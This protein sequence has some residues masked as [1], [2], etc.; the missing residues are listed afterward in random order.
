MAKIILGGTEIME[1]RREIKKGVQDKLWNRNFILLLQGQLISI[2]GD[3]I[4]EM[5]L[6]IWILAKTR[7][8]TL[9]GIIMATSILPKIFIS[10]FAGTFI[11]RHSRKKILIVSDVVSGITVCIIGIATIIGCVEIWMVILA[12]IIVG[13]CGCF[14]NPTINSAIPDVVPKNSL[15]KANSALSSIGTMNNMAGYAFGGFLVQIIGAPILFL[16]N[17]VSF[18]LSA[19]AEGF[20]KIPRIEPSIKKVTFREDMKAGFNY[21]KSN[22]GL[23]YLYITI[24]FLNFFASMSMTLTLPLFKMH[25]QLGVGL[26]GIA[27]AINTFGMLVG[28]SILAIKGLKKERQF[29]L[30]IISGILISFTMIIYSMTLNFTL[31][32][33]LFFVDGVCL[34]WMGSLLQSSMQKFVPD[35]MRSKVFAFRNM[36]SSSLM[37]LGMILAGILGEKVKLNVIIGVDYF[38]FLLLFIYLSF[39]KSVKN[40]I[41]L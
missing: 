37:P 10:P 25:K 33:I 4:Y 34:A 24:A 15:L 30:F 8:L 32:A 5:A 1:N 16:L 21:V 11:D 31:I 36:L 23:R 2:F 41:N 26:F 12:G 9:M 19:V 22:K 13:I 18:L 7:S 3:T 40:I 35:N 38:I 14:F 6:R 20:V 29:F 17:G 28:Y 27:M 39:L